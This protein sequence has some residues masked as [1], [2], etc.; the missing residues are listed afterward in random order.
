M[1]PAIARFTTGGLGD[2]LAAKLNAAYPALGL[3][4]L[5]TVKAQL[6]EGG[7]GCFPAHYD[8]SSSFSNRSITCLL[9]LNPSWAPGDGGELRILPFPL[10]SAD[11][12]PRHDRLALF[13]ST[14]TLHRVMPAT[15]RR[16]CLSI[17]FR[18]ADSATL[19]FPR[20]VPPAPAGGDGA[21]LQKLWAMLAHEP[22]RRVLAK[23]FHRREYAR[24][25]ADAFVGCAGLEAA[26]NLDAME[27]DK[28][29][30][31]LEPQLQDAMRAT[32]PLLPPWRA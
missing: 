6:N 29:V 9:Y 12:R 24:S 10:A 26:L 2:R 22:S 23:V 1:S 21:V 16:L 31:L 30:A 32:L 20:A 19:W 4:G 3:R 5:D 27:T 18:S 8:T 25:F 28:A 13:C 15:A 17:W 14:A 11:V 7:G